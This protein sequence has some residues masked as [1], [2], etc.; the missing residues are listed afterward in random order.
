MITYYSINVTNKCNKAC[1]Y[2]VNKSYVN[3]NEYLDI[4]KFEDLKNWLEKE[5]KVD[6][7]VEIAGTGEPTLCAWLPNLLE[8]LEQKKTWVILK[9]NGFK[10]DKWR[11]TFDNVLVILTKHD[12]TDDYLLD[13]CKYLLPI[14]IICTAITEEALQKDTEPSSKIVIFF[15]NK[16]HEINK[17]FCVS[18]DGKVRFLPCIVQDM[19]TVWDYKPEGWNCISLKECPF[20]VN[21]WN[22]IEYLKNPFDLPNECNHV[23][24]KN[25]QKE[26]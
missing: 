5:I 2:C 14:D 21:A 25:F 7:I 9:T 24:V 16:V 3:K 11:L 17:A 23:Q 8:Y 6:D 4:I 18:P 1:L 22:F 19:G 12:S 26:V 13:K 20:L 10:L 15:K